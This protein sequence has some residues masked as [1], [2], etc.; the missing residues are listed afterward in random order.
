VA[1]RPLSAEEKAGGEIVARRLGGTWIE[2]DGVNAP[3]GT[4]D[5]DIVFDDGRE[6]VALE[7]TSSVDGDELATRRLALDRDWPAP[8]LDHH[9]WLLVP[10]EM[11]VRAVRPLMTGVVPCL[12]VLERHDVGSVS[13]REP[14]REPSA[15]V[16]AAREVFALG[17][18]RATRLG[19]QPD[20]TALVMA[21]VHGGV[22]SDFDNLN[23]LVER[24]AEANAEK[25]KASG[26]AD[27]HLFVWMHDDGG[28]LTMGTLPAPPSAATLSD[29]VDVVWVATGPE[30][31]HALCRVLY[32]LQAG[33]RWEDVSAL[34]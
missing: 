3:D 27:R 24:C 16:D 6:T 19:R 2:R 31:N 14:P 15:V 20:G 33:G 34:D 17:A 12:E 13:R 28:E 9:W 7:V 23:E 11:D 22:G 18:D 4:H 26:S 5:L 29:G 8:T 21:S 25:L 32:R 30:G 1:G 10:K